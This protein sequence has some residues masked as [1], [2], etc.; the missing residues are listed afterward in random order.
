MIEHQTPVLNSPLCVSNLTSELPS[1][2]VGSLHIGIHTGDNLAMRGVAINVV[3]HPFR[4]SLG[5]DIRSLP[6]AFLSKSEEIIGEY[7]AVAVDENQ[8]KRV[9]FLCWR[10]IEG[11]S[12]GVFRALTRMFISLS[13]SALDL[14]SSRPLFSESCCSVAC[15]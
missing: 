13:T 10:Q 14:L 6:A 8:D 4:H 1:V 11:Y 9:E 3:T 5:E 2:G 15:R 7:H 12:C